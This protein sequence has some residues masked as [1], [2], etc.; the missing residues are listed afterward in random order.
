MG[1]KINDSFIGQEINGVKILEFFV[2]KGRS[3][4]KCLCECGNAFIDRCEEIKNKEN[5]SCGCKT[6]ELLG[7]QRKLPGNTAVINK[8]M[9]SYIAGAKRRDL[10]FLL[11][12]EEFEEFLLANCGYCGAPPISTAWR[13]SGKFKKKEQIICNGIDRK[14]NSLG[15]TKDN[16]L[17]ACRRCNR[18]KLDSSFEDFQIWINGLVNFYKDK[19]I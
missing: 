12:R 3:Y 7:K 5:R 16:C 13:V 9:R 15:Y 4:F 14:N 17:T 11:S 1:A 19:F 2:E 8:I 6:H 10:D 18:A